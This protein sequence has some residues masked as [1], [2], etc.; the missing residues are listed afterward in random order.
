M[1]DDSVLHAVLLASRR[2]LDPARRVWGTGGWRPP[3]ERE[4]LDWLTLVR[5]LGWDVDVRYL[6]DSPEAWTMGTGCRVVIA[7]CDPDEVSPA[8]ASWLEDAADQR[9]VVVMQR[10]VSQVGLEAPTA[11]GVPP[12]APDIMS[13]G[14]EILWTG[15]G[16]AASWRPRRAIRWEPLPA[17]NEDRVWATFDGRPVILALARASGWMVKLAFHPSAARDADGA[18]TD[19][20]RHLLLSACAPPLA[21]LDFANTMVLR[22]DD[23]GGAQNVYSRGWS[24]P[25]LDES[26]WAAIG[27]VL[28]RFGGRLSIGYVAGWVDDGDAARGRLRVGGVDV[29]RQP[30]AVYPSRLVEY[31]DVCGA[32]PGTVH[33]YAAE[34]RGIQY[35]RDKNLAEV[36]LHGY[37]HIHPDREAWLAA[38]DRETATRWYRE[39]GLAAASALAARPDREHPLA[40]AVEA[41]QRAFGCTPTTL[42]P[43]GDEWTDAVLQR[44]LD[45][46]LTL[47]ASYYVALRHR[48]RF[49]WATHLESPYLDRPEA[50]WLDAHLPVVGYF[51]DRE[52]ALEGPQWFERWLSGWRTGR[53]VH[54]PAVGWPQWFERWLSGWRAC[55]AERFIDFRELSAA[56]AMRFRAAGARICVVHPQPS[57]FPTGRHVPVIVRER[58]QFTEELAVDWTAP[59][60]RFVQR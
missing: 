44:A 38:A 13:G 2:E 52:P 33:D 27:D 28:T 18:A 37:T 35:L 15:P 22:M 10:A 31:R 46:E 58:G 12:I 4:A 55:G 21:A 56:L 8:V 45:L 43:P 47:V 59:V 20:L 51:H 24:Y 48:G 23:P 36:E 26:A 3:E 39:L 30:G 19:L 60:A 34:F 1:D 53:G 57:A 32:A 49:C 50:R 25:K 14:R 42:I 40:L 54:S 29:P 9:P 16:S 41:I 11:G 6:E 5:L 17:P 7:A